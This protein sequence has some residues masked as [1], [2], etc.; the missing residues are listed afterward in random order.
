MH[1]HTHMYIHTCVHSYTRIHKHP[2]HKYTFLHTNAE[3]TQHTLITTP[4]IAAHTHPSHK[5]TYTQM[6]NTHSTH[7]SHPLK[8][9]NTYSIHTSHPLKLQHTHTQGGT[10]PA[11]ACIAPAQEEGEAW[12]DR[13]SLQVG[14]R[15]L[16]VVIYGLSPCQKA[17]LPL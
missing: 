7:T 13:P 4:E 9:Q 12:V 16:L 8:L 17:W 5:Y 11:S 10:L 15:E 3:H 2:L 1:G 6:Q 14:V